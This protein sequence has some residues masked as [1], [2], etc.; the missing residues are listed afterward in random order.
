MG[1]ESLWRVP[2]SDSCRIHPDS[3][4]ILHPHGLGLTGIK[5]PGRAIVRGHPGLANVILPHGQGETVQ[6]ESGQVE[7]GSCGQARGPWARAVPR[8][9][10]K[11]ATGLGVALRISME[12][13]HLK[14]IQSITGTIPLRTLYLDVE[15][16]SLHR[17]QLCKSLGVESFGQSCLISGQKS[18]L[19]S[20]SPPFIAQKGFQISM[21]ISRGDSSQSIERSSS[22]LL[23][24]FDRSKLE[25]P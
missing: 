11:A 14:M 10:R 17:S 7:H 8:V 16:F 22:E 6:E 9:P 1:A 20:F 21:K 24:K 3:H 25:R 13:P 18:S 2:T 15:S 19:T 4:V 23:M 12:A 5:L